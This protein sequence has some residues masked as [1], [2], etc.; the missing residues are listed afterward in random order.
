VDR[1]KGEKECLNDLKDFAINSIEVKKEEVDDLNESESFYEQYK[2][3]IRPDNTSFR[4][5]QMT[6]SE[7]KSV[8]LDNLF[9]NTR[10][11]DY[12]NSTQEKFDLI[13][14]HN[15]L[16]FTNQNDLLISKIGSFLKSDGFIYIRVENQSK[17]NNPEKRTYYDKGKFIQ[18]LDQTFNKGFL[19]Q[20]MKNNDWHSLVFINQ[21][22]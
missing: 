16:H 13:I 11:E 12:I 4:K 7:F 10:L 8:I 14:C 17:L 6:E 19:Y 5:N 18:E 15:V 21:E 3:S 22:L 9:F 20:S 1:A 2:K